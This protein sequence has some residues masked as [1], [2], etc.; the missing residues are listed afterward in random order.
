MKKLQITFELSLLRAL[1]IL[2]LLIF[3]FNIYYNYY[4]KIFSYVRGNFIYFSFNEYVTL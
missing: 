4:E 2:C 1:G 3:R